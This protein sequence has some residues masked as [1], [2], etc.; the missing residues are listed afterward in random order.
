MG[1]DDWDQE[2]EEVPENLRRKWDKEDS[3]DALQEKTFAPCPYCRKMIERHSFS[4]IYCG[5]RVFKNSGPL[6]RLKSAFDSGS[7][8]LTVFLILALILLLSLIF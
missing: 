3:H 5:E 4:C 1:D 6:G 2:E 7:A 8:G